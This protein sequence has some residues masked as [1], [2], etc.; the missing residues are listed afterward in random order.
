MSKRIAW[1]ILGTG[2]IANV[3]AKG[4]RESKTGMLTAVASRNQETAN[5]FGEK[6]NIPRRYNSYEALIADESV[7]A[8]YIATPHSMHAKW[9]IQAAR[10]GKHILCEKPIAINA[11]QAEAIIEAARQHDV[12]LMEAFMYRCHP[13]TTKLIQLIRDKAIGEV[14]LIQATFSFYA[15]V[16]P[17][18]RLLNNALGGGGILD[19]GGYCTSIARLIAGAALH[20]NVAEPLQVQGAGHIDEQ[21]RVDEYASALL[22]FP[23]DILAQLFAGVQAYG[24]NVVRIFGTEGSLYIPNPWTPG[25]EGRNASIV[26]TRDEGKQVEEI[27]LEAT[28]N[29]YA[30]EADTVAEYLEARQAPFVTWQD[31]LGNMQTLDRWRNAIGLVYDDE[32]AESSQ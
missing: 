27:M 12:F 17:Q 9:T 4:V 13:Q 32:Q 26:I 31:T 18:H 29:L 2:L 16:S 11:R 14:R 6:W 5:Q 19:V 28:T 22:T 23:D 24:E 25:Y 15:Q 20:K 30:I 3:F 10:A 21:S 7:Q 8:V 1:G